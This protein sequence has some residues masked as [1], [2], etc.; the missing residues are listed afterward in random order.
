MSTQYSYPMQCLAAPLFWF[1]CIKLSDR[2]LT[3]SPS[4]MVVYQELP[5]FL[6]TCSHIS[7][8]IGERHGYYRNVVT[9]EL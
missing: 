2:I 6:P 7:E 5:V 1:S 4:V 9:I 3:G 8:M